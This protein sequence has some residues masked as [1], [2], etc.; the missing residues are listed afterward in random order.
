M[1]TLREDGAK[2]I[3][4]SNGNVK[5]ISPDEKFIVMKYFNGDVKETNLASNTFKYYY[6]STKTWHIQNPDGSEVVEFPK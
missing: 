1:E 3:K 2:E 6:A 4:Y 5:T